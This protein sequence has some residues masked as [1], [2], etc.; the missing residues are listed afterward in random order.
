MI[1]KYMAI[2]VFAATETMQ[3]V[4]ESPKEVAEYC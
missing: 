3:M 1:T 2:I 4:V